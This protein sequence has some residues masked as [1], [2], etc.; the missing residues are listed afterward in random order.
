MKRSRGL[1]FVITGAM[2]W[3]IGGTVSQKLFQEYDVDINWLVS[4]RL[5]IA[6]ILL[7]AVQFMKKDRSQLLGVWKQKHTAAAL[8]IFGLF[9]MLA[10]QYTYMASIQ[11]GNAAVATLLQYLAPVMIILYLIVR[12][13]SVLSG[14]DLIT[15]LLALT[16]CFL[17]LTNGSLTELSV[18]VSAIVWGILS[19]VALA[20]YTLYAVP[21]LKQFD[22]LVIVGWAMVIGGAALSAVQFPS[23]MDLVHL[24][25]EAL[26]YLLFVIVFGTMLA[27]WFYIESLQSLSP[28]EASLFGTVEPL[29]AVLS[30]VL[31]LSEPFGAFQWAGAGCIVLMM[32]LLAVQKEPALSFKKDLA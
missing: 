14:N 3:G 31:W 8:L 21:L 24:P 29:A 27:F 15:V 20:F 26:M 17:L 32:V 22:S 13:Q 30:T 18:P 4:A 5:L 10:V 23:P 19:G 12:K 11:L 2:F 16:G 1:F 9:G 25:A 28:K 7:L 6:G